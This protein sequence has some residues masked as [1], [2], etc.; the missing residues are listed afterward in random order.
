VVAER[1]NNRIGSSEFPPQPR[2][3]PVALVDRE[4]LVPL[5]LVLVDLIS[6]TSATGSTSRKLNF[7]RYDHIS[8]WHCHFDNLITKK[9]L[10]VSHIKHG[11][12]KS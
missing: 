11:T 1:I 5:E 10:K 8:W 7:V 4:P 9:V 6:T 12:N 3:K 2:D